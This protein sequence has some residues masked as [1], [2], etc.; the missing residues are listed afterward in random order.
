MSQ[1][2]INKIFSDFLNCKY[3]AYLKL[4]GVV[5]QK[6]EYEQ[7]QNRLSNEYRTHACTHFLSTNDISR[8]PLT[9]LPL[10]EFLELRPDVAINITADVLGFTL[11]LDAVTL[12]SSSKP[13]YIPITFIHKEKLSKEDKLLLAFCGFFLGEKT[14]CIPVFGRI[15]HGRGYT[16]TRVKLDTLI[17]KANDILKNII[18]LKN[19]NTPPKLCLN[20]HCQVCE[21][22][23]ECYA[24]AVE[25]DHLS[26][27]EGLKTKDITKLNNKGIFTVT[28]LSYT[29]RPRRKRKR[30]NKYRNP[31]RP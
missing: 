8:I 13:E 29:F 14:Q 6:S 7:L 18:E 28:Q 20:K 21:F 2:V 9:D 16:N 4:T 17:P 31:H 27:L 12:N 19:S 22:R 10:S 23:K 25:K 11:F 5:G 24:I 15:I 3:K 1:Y 30:P 26:L